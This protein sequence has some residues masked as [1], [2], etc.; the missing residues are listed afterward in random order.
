MAGCHHRLS[1]LNGGVGRQSRWP[2]A[3]S[4]KEKEPDT[5]GGFPRRLGKECAQLRAVL[6]TE[7]HGGQRRPPTQRRWPQLRRLGLSSSH[8]T[9]HPRYV[10]VDKAT[11]ATTPAI[12]HGGRRSKMAL[13]QSNRAIDWPR[14]P[15]TWTVHSRCTF[16]F[17][18]LTCHYMI[19]D[20]CYTWL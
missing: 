19:W 2:C 7:K 17:V 3:F 5:R 14:Y 13:N 15:L 20:S 12:G 9:S 11:G 18:Q 6:D 10:P 8:Q 16:R 1:A 4:E